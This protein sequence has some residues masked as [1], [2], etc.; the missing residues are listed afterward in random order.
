MTALFDDQQITD[1]GSLRKLDDD[2]IREL[3]HSI[4]KEGHPISI[5]PQNRLKLLVFWAKHMWRTSH[6]VDELTDRISS[7]Y[8]TRRPWK[9]ASTNPR[10]PSP[11]R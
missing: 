1:F 3:C 4:T 8:R 10:S 5:I 9:T 6:G 7:L 2:A 11:P